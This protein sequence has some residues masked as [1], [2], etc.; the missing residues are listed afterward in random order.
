MLAKPFQIWN[1][2]K[3]SNYGWAVSADCGQK[4]KLFIRSLSILLE[5]EDQYNE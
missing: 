5:N 2:E 4:R 3:V 1:S